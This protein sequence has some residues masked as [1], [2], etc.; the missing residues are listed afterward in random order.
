M[1]SSHLGFGEAELRELNPEARSGSMR[2]CVSARAPLHA[3]KCVQ[4]RIPQRG[5]FHTSLQVRAFR[6]YRTQRVQDTACKKPSVYR[7][8]LAQD[9]ACTTPRVQ[10]PAYTG[11]R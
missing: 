7:T 11:H 9:P 1:T 10:D 6:A 2:V 5:E 4:K 3:C 8:P